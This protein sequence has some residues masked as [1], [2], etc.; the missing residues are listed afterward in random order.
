MDTSSQKKDPGLHPPEHVVSSSSEASE[1]RKLSGELL[2]ERRKL[3]AQLEQRE[4][5]CT[6]L[7]STWASTARFGK[8]WM[9]CERFWKRQWVWMGGTPRMWRW[10]RCG[11][12][13][14]SLENLA[15]SFN[16]CWLEGKQLKSECG[17]PQCAVFT[18]VRISS[19]RP[20][21]RVCS[22][23]WIAQ[24][25]MSMNFWRKM[26]ARFE[27]QRPA[28]ENVSSSEFHF[29]SLSCVFPQFSS[30]FHMSQVFHF[31]LDMTW[32]VPIHRGTPS[33]HPF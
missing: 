31:D 33:H 3:L 32:G 18:E 27:W 7:L 21:S 4:Q 19:W 15:D 26:S 25:L 9:A 5:S 28:T 10:L 14:L 16:C 12:V 23:L 20:C 13:V 30:F 8:I 17:L 29:P 11:G 2:R 22:R 6:E 1:L 24:R